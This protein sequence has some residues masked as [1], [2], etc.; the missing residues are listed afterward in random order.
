MLEIASGTDMHVQTGDTQSMVVCAAQAIV[1]LLVPDPVLG[2]LTTRV[3]LLAVPMPEAGVDAQC[4][5]VSRCQFAQLIDHVWRADIHVDAMFDHQSDRVPVK[6]IR[7]VHDLG[8][9]A[10]GDIAGRQCTVDFSCTDR[11][12]QY[13]VASHQVQDRDVGAS[14]LRRT[15]SRRIAADRPRDRGSSPRRTRRW[16][17]QTARRAR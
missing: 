2:M 10:T 11:I 8:W 1:Q 14:L 16:A 5:I 12:H 13:S 17:S 15:E 9:L 4:D 3:G 7:R 6:D